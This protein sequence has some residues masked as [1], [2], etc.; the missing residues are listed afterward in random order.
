MADDDFTLTPRFGDQDQAPSTPA[1]SVPQTAPPADFT[2]SSRVSGA[3]T[4]A[5]PTPATPTPVFSGSIL[6]LTRYSDNSVGFD[7]NAGVVGL[8]KRT[9]QGAWN[10]ATLPGDVATGKVDPNSQQAI[11]RSANLAGLASMPLVTG[12]AIPGALATA[13][14]VTP[15][16]ADV[17][18]AAASAGYDAARNM[19]V[20]YHPLAVSAMAQAVQSNL[21][22]QGVLPELAPQTHAILNKLQAVPDVPSTVPFSSLEAARRAFGRA[23]GAFTNPTEQF[24]A[25]NAQNAIDDFVTTADPSSVVAGPAAA[26]AKTVKDARAN[27]AAG[28]RSDRINDREEAAALNAAAANSGQNTGNAIRQRTKGILA[29]PKLSAGYNPAEL[30]SLRSVVT[31]TPISNASRIAGNVL[32]GGGGMH[33]YL[34]GVSGAAAGYEAAGVPGAV[35]GATVPLL[36]AG[37]KHLD[38]ALTA[39]RLKAADELVRSRSPLARAQA[40]AAPST[41]STGAALGPALVQSPLQQQFNQQQSTYAKGGSVRKKTKEELVNRL[42]DLAEKAKKATNKQTEPLLNVPDDA[43]THALAVAQTAI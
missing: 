38:S 21:F 7:S 23:A 8:A 6:P 43:I 2:F 4:V 42:M 9:L 15:P 37:A 34:T 26:V 32:G 20:E 12:E 25:K 29:S 27:A 1:N 41:I 3:P 33:S 13:A 10:A 36:G 22:D 19:G 24:A 18:H 40:A 16:T 11:E 5:N 31:G 35:A 30:D 28:F 14:K 39:A 17:L